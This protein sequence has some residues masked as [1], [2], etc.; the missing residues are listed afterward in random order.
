VP[1]LDWVTL[2]VPL[3]VF[4]GPDLATLDGL[5][6]RI[7]R[8]DPAT[9]E[10]AWETRA[11]DSIASDSHQVTYRVGGEA[12][13][14][15]GSPARVLGDGDAVFGAGPSA[16]LDLVGCVDAMLDY[17]CPALRVARPP[18][19][20]CK[21]IRVDVTQ[22]L[23]LGDRD[24]V[25]VALRALRDCEGG[26]YKVNNPDGDTVY[27]SKKSHLRSGKAY[28]K[29][30]HLAYMMRKKDYHGRWYSGDEIGLAMAL[31]RL[32]LSLKAQWWREKRIGKA[33][34]EVTAADLYGQWQ[35]YFERMMGEA[36]VTEMNIEERVRAAAETDGQA[37]AAIGC[38]ALIKAYGWEKAR[39]MQAKRTW[40][41]NLK[42]L[43]AAGLSDADVSAGNV[44]PFRRKVVE[45]QMVN[46]WEELRRLTAMAKA[47]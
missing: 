36:E 26:R 33:W 6:D 34:Y 18:V 19:E 27:W 4:S 46:S 24:Q 21:V 25:R 47:A 29:G 10:V 22:N 8:F 40:Y 20:A 23:L 13:M 37:K 5:G 39:Q 41:R 15:Q 45:F 11:W 14:I 1:L 9:G 16:A 44:V 28:A 2:K 12:L 17:L 7:R 35:D 42:V 3:E 30:P 32:E 38:W 43:R 31:L